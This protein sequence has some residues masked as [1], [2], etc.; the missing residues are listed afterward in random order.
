MH[1]LC[2]LVCTCISG[3]LD[4]ANQEPLKSAV[5]NKCLK[6]LKYV[7]LFLINRKLNSK[8]LAFI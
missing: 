8:Y 4:S 7:F 2:V 5:Y 1:V 3:H 6:Y